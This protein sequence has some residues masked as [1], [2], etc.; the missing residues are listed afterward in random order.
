MRQFLEGRRLPRA[1]IVRFGAVASV[2]AS[3]AAIIPGVAGGAPAVPKGVT[4]VVDFPAGEVCPFPVNIVIRDGTKF[5]DTGQGDVIQAGPLSAT[6]TNTATGA[7]QSF[8]A[9]GP[10]FSTGGSATP[11]VGTGP[12]LIAQPASRNVGPPFLIYTTGRVT[13][14]P[15][16]TIASRTGRVT[17]VCAEL[18]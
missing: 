15:N 8:N 13:W 10:L 2:L 1:R 12:Q 3:A 7:T 6:V 11:T 9:S 5:H 14:T 16:F 18:S 4:F 17:D